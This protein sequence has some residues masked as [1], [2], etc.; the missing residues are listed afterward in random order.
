M[1]LDY[2]GKQKMEATVTTPN[3]TD[4][5]SLKVAFQSKSNISS[6]M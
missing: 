6:Y 1:N 4:E 2:N 3:N 5:T